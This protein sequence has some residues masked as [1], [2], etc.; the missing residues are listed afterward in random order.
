MSAVERVVEYGMADVLQVQSNLM[1]S[2]RSQE[3]LNSHSHSHHVGRPQGERDVGEEVRNCAWS[4]VRGAAVACVA[5]VV[6]VVRV[7]C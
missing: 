3:S 2:A 1:G 5:R 7:R 6:C 4:A